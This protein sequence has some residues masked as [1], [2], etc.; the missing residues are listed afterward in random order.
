LLWAGFVAICLLLP[1]WVLDG[2]TT[3]F[4]PF[5]MSAAGLLT[6]P[7]AAYLGKIAQDVPG[8]GKQAAG[9]SYVPSLRVVINVVAAVFG[10][11]LFMLLARLGTLLSGDDWLADWLLLIVTC[12][13]AGGFG[14]HINVNRFS[15]HAVYRN[16]LVRAC[17]G[18][19]RPDRTPGGFTDIDPK[20]NPRLADLRSPERSGGEAA[21]ADPPPLKRV[22]RM[23]FPVVNVT[24]N[25]V[26][27]RNTAWTERKGESFTITPTRCGVAYVRTEAYAGN[28]K[29]TGPHDEGRGITLGTAIT[30]SGAA[31][32]PRWATTPRR[33][34]P[35]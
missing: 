4:V 2:W 17:F 8:N 11:A 10:I 3:S 31:V 13:L 21:P 6:G 16:R 9:G 29:E 24:L 33:P 19:A 22:P 30:L 25:L 27:G 14:R 20:D 28:E 15:M 34:P 26:A 12:L 18:S 32:S 23:L 5:V 1:G 7:L 35:S